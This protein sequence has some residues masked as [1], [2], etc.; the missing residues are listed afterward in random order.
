MVFLRFHLSP[1]QG[2]GYGS[3]IDFI[4]HTDDL[5]TCVVLQPLEN[6]QAL[7][8][9]QRQS[10]PN[11]VHPSDHLPVGA[12][13]VGRGAPLTEGEGVEAVEEG[14]GG[15]G[16]ERRAHCTGTVAVAVERERACAVCGANAITTF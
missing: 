10:L 8:V 11:Q 6:V 9:A 4:L 3:V 2:S 1:Q 14:V 7:R 5:Q 16:G 13:L 15:P 12:V